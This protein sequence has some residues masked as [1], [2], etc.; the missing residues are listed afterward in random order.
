MSTGVGRDGSAFGTG[1]ETSLCRQ[2][3]TVAR[4]RRKGDSV[5]QVVTRFLG[6]R[7]GT[8]E[9]LCWGGVFQEGE[10]N[11]GLAERGGAWSVMHFSSSL[12]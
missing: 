5:F 1:Q 7:M 4:V 8:R 3:L 12:H 2:A 11:S 9:P 10:A 6:R